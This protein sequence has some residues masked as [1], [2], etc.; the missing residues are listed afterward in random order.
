MERAKETLEIF[1]YLFCWMAACKKELY[2]DGRLFMIILFAR[3]RRSIFIQRGKCKRIAIQTVFTALCLLA[4]KRRFFGEYICLP[5]TS[6]PCNQDK[7]A[8][9]LTHQTHH[10]HLMNFLFFP[11]FSSLTD[12]RAKKPAQHT[13]PIQSQQSC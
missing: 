6:Q 7:V 2:R 8:P 5:E 12:T 11:S 9:H 1:F 13:I 4:Q 3:K 10:N